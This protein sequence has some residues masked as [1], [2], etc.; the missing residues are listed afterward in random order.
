MF[1]PIIFSYNKFFT[2]NNRTEQKTTIN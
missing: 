1:M 2:S